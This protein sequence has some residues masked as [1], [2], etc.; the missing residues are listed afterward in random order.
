M[1]EKNDRVDVDSL[2]LVARKGEYMP[3]FKAMAPTALKSP[4]VRSL[5]FLITEFPVPAGI[6]RDRNELCEQHHVRAD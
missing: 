6:V 5:G 2:T 4:A 1:R 3:K